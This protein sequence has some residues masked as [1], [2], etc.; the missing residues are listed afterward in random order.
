MLIAFGGGETVT[1]WFQ[2]SKTI[3]PPFAPLFE[4]WTGNGLPV[5]ATYRTPPLSLSVTVIARWPFTVVVAPLVS[6]PWLVSVVSSSLRRSVR[7]VI[8]A[9]SPA[10][11][12]AFNH[13]PWN[14]CAA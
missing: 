13:L 12:G 7:D 6:L 2:R 9:N 10:V 5:V 3:R 14:S 8:D 4:I 11:A 1:A